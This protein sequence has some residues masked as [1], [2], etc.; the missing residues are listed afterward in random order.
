MCAFSCACTNTIHSPVCDL[1]PRF[2]NSVGGGGGACGGMTE[3]WVSHGKHYCEYCNANIQNHKRAIANHESSAFHKGNVQKF[4]ETKKKIREND[5]KKQQE[6]MAE[7]VRVTMAATAAEMGLP[8][9]KQ[10]EE[11]PTRPP[12]N[13]P[14]PIDPNFH[15]RQASNLAMF[16]AHNSDVIDAMHEKYGAEA[17]EKKRKEAEE[18]ERVR[19]M[20]E[21]KKRQ[22]EAS[23]EAVAND[24]DD[25]T[26]K[27]SADDVYAAPMPGKWE[28]VK[29]AAA[30][31]PTKAYETKVIVVPRVQAP[32][33]IE[34]ES[35][36]D[37]EL[38]KKEEDEIKQEEDVPAEAVV[39][40]KR[41]AGGPKQMRTQRIG[42]E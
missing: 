11:S 24:A 35:D 9:P 23:G 22:R 25:S 13:A 31:V 4:L 5:D 14:P 37:D 2:F 12:A 42:H 27:R 15:T 8:A 10:R 21:E 17:A 36:E 40:A 26:R 16:Y 28:V 41:R 29:P 7:I 30:A 6:V 32:A 34:E 1:L 39:F 3:Y 19:K 33:E 18:L 38:A 20:L